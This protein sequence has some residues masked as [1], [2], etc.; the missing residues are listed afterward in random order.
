MARIARVLASGY[1]PRIT[2]RGVQS[3]PIFNDDGDRGACPE[4]MAEKLQRFSVDVFG[5]VFGD[6]PRTVEINLPDICND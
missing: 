1:P 2:Q 4:F 6:N 3:I 5:L